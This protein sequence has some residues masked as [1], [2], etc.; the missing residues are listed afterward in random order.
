MRARLDDVLAHV[1]DPAAV[2]EALGALGAALDQW[3]A[4]RRAARADA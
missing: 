2:S 4:E 1:D 3:R